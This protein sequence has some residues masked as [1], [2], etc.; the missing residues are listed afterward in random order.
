MLRSKKNTEIALFLLRFTTSYCG[1]TIMGKSRDPI[2]VFG[3]C[4]T[5]PLPFSANYISPIRYA[6]EKLPK[7]D[8]H[9]ST[10][11]VGVLHEIDGD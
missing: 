2:F 6:I 5:V 10:L 11:I 9:F 3:S 1:G 4:H 8:E 7:G